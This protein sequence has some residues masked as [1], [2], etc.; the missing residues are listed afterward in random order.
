MKFIQSLILILLLLFLSSTPSFCNGA[1]SKLTPGTSADTIPVKDNSLIIDNEEIII[2]NIKNS[3]YKSKSL[4]FQIMY[5]IRNNSINNESYLIAFP[6]D[7]NRL[8][9][10]LKVLY[11]DQTINYEIRD[12]IDYYSTFNVDR[13]Y[14]LGGERIPKVILFK[15]F[16]KPN[17]SGR[18]FV[19]YR[20]NGGLMDDKHKHPF[21]YYLQPAKYWSSFKNITITINIPK[22][23]DL[24]S[25]FEFKQIS[26]NNIFVNKY[27]YTNNELPKNDLYF[28]L[29]SNDKNYILIS[30]ISL[31]FIL[32]ILM[33]IRYR[34][35]KKRIVYK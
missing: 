2:D 23:Y 11:N 24:I 32:F 33:I 20:T 10:N 31:V 13:K 15:I 25:D 26:N 19:T 4:R 3:R 28:E 35:S 34:L 5:H 27:I 6:I 16:I 17:E 12:D 9:K 14:T 21:L 8:L 18:L 22:H 30:I 7:N 29:H 1:P